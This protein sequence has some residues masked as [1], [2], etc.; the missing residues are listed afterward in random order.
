MQKLTNAN[1][2]DRG[3]AAVVSHANG[4]LGNMRYCRTLMGAHAAYDLRFPAEFGNFKTE[5]GLRGRILGH[6]LIKAHPDSRGSEVDAGEE[7]YRAF[8]RSAWLRCGSV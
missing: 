7:R 5:A 6:R 2:D 3:K 1:A 8:C 4:A